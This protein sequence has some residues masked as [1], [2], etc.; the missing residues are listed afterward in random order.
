[1]PVLTIYLSSGENLTDV[2]QFEWALHSVMKFPLVKSNILTTP[3]YPP[4]TKYLLLFE[5]QSD[6]NSSDSP[7]Y[8][9][10]SS[11]ASGYDFLRSQ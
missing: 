2:T 4:V 8:G 9:E 10:L 5:I 3:S 1:L 7:L 6:N 11:T